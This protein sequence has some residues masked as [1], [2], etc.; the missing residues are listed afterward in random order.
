MNL[1]SEIHEL[2]IKL[3]AR[4]M[5]PPGNYRRNTHNYVIH[6]YTN[7]IIGLYLSKNYNVIPVF[8]RRLNKALINNAEHQDH[9]FYTNVRKYSELM[10]EFVQTQDFN[11][12][13]IDILNI[14]AS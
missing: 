5:V 10:K 1:E 2:H 13:A 14:I 6:Q 8:F 7:C 11:E 4:D 9:V 12:Q 3:N